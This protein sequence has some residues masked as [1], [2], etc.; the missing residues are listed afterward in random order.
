MKKVVLSCF[1]VVGLALFLMTSTVTFSGCDSLLGVGDTIRDTVSVEKLSVPTIDSVVVLE[2]AESAEIHFS[3]SHV[4]K[5]NFRGYFLLS[6]NSS[7]ATVIEK[8]S[9]ID[10]KAWTGTRS[11]TVTIERD[12]KQTFWIAAYN[13]ANDRGQPVPAHLYGRL[14][15][16]GTISRFTVNSTD[17]G[18]DVD[19]VPELKTVEDGIRADGNPV[20]YAT[21]SGA[22][23]IVEEPSNTPGSLCITPIG[24]AVIFKSNATDI[25]TKA[26]I[27]DIYEKSYEK[28]ITSLSSYDIDVFARGKS[29]RSIPEASAKIYSIQEDDYFIVITSAKNVARVKVEATNGKVDATNGKVDATLIV[30]Q[31]SGRNAGELL[32]KKA[33]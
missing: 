13:K 29:I 26:E 7:T 19:G 32:Y 22:D 11:F 14:N 2:G 8:D 3:G 24:G 15:K 10:S 17:D 21:N 31:D 18:L 4:I 25:Y 16:E 20:M 27:N 9:V 12:G 28:E 1:S 23:F 33:L 6:S 5:E 30:Y